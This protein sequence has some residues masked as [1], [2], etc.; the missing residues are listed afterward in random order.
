MYGMLCGC[1]TIVP[2]IESIRNT[3]EI[4][5]FQVHV[6]RIIPVGY[7]GDRLEY[8]YET[9]LTDAADIFM[10]VD[11]NAMAEGWTIEKQSAHQRLYTKWLKYT[12]HYWGELTVNMSVRP[13]ERRVRVV[14]E[15]RGRRPVE[16]P[17][18]SAPEPPL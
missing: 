16:S 1:E 6:V 8:E 5:V 9:A 11:R 18:A 13:D 2:S 14:R 17:S 4:Q 15:T 3:P 10:L 12:A 7:D